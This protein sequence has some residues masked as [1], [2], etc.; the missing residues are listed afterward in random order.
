MRFNSYGEEK[1][2]FELNNDFI[3][4]NSFSN[5]FSYMYILSI[6]ALKGSNI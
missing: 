3:M 5:M 6:P 2:R 4:T 1:R